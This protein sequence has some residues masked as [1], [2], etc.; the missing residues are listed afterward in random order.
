MSEHV[1]TYVS[2][3]IDVSYDK[4]RCLHA[5]E[6][7]KGLPEVFDVK[8]RP[9]IQPQ[10]A[11]ANQVAEIVERCPTGAL[12]YVRKDGVEN[13][14]APEKTTIGQVDGNRI[15]VTGHLDIEAEEGSIKATRATLC[16]C[17]YS[18]NKPFCDNSEQ[19][20]P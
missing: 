18:E 9:W 3:G 1:K 11:H 12:T 15:Y 17:G 19:C 13:E 10:H 7:V 8:E 4:N 20:K 16:G 14:K 6:C 5:A 2:D